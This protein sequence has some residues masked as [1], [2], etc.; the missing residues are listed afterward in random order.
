MCVYTESITTVYAV[1]VVCIITAEI[2]DGLSSDSSCFTDHALFPLLFYVEM[3]M[4]SGWKLYCL[5]YTHA[6]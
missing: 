2:S 4:L 3:L 5:N 6:H 1:D